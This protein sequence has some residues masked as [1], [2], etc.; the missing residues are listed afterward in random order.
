MGSFSPALTELITA[1]KR[2]SFA[3]WVSKSFSAILDQGV[4]SGSN[5]LVSICLARWLVPKQYGAY[6]L[7]FQCFMIVGLVHEALLQE[8]MLVFGRSTY[9]DSFREYYRVLLRI[10]AAVGGVSFLLLGLSAAV[11]RV[12]GNSALLSRALAGA[13]LAAP[14]LLLW[15]LARRALYAR[16]TPQVALW[17]ALLY[18][19][20]ILGGLLIIQQRGLLSP[21]TALLVM[22]VAGLVVGF[23]LVI[24]LR[25]KLKTGETSPTLTEVSRR[26]WT[27]GRWA[28][29]AMLVRTLPSSTVYYFLLGQF[30]GLAQVGALKALLNLTAPL[31]QVF[32]SFG[33]ISLPHAAETH[34]QRGRVGLEP[35]AWKLALLYAGGGVAYWIFVILCRGPILRFLYAGK[36]MLVGPLIPW[37]GLASTLSLIARAQNVALRGMQSS[38]SVFVAYGISGVIDLVIGVP[39]TVLMGLRGVVITEILSSG[40]ALVAGFILLRRALW[41]APEI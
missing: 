38:F 21:F 39:A 35:L 10:F 5:F 31:T 30:S 1:W 3:S 34:H 2:P 28:L 11:V 19:A 26:H 12:L 18:A 20:V 4:T 13:A 37:L 8:P 23:T 36:Y 32:A 7:A 6:A 15:W 27:Y 17:G 25:A 14:G 29:A 33:L 22:G 40:A 41:R 24:R 9:K 16:L